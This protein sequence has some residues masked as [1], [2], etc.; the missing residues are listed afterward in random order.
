MDKSET[1]F[2]GNLDWQASNL[3]ALQ[4]FGSI[5]G[6]LIGKRTSPSLMY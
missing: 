2:A 1:L 3:F 5:W 4:S 6:S